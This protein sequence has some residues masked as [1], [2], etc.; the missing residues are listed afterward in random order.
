[1]VT[2]LDTSVLARRSHHAVGAEVARLILAREA[3][4]CHPLMLEVLYSTRSAAE[5]RAVREELEALI[6]LPIGPPEWER[7]VDVYE[8]LSEVGGA[9]QRSVKHPDLL[10]AAA[11][12]SAGAE[13]LHYDEDFDRIAE[14]TGQPTRW[15]AD[16]GSL[17]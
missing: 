8:R 10:V 3:A 9:H 2:L 4:T 5:F 15:V 11:A 1:V 6:L 12:E 16:R 17:G 14:I 13:I 7:A